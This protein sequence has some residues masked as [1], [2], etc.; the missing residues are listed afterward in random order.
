MAGHSPHAA[1]GVVPL[2]PVVLLCF[3]LFS[4]TAVC[5]RTWEALSQEIF[6]C[7]KNHSAAGSH[8]ITGAC[9]RSHLSVAPLRVAHGLEG[10]VRG[11]VF[12]RADAPDPQPSQV[13][14]CLFAE[15]ALVHGKGFCLLWAS[16]CSW[17][18]SLQG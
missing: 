4:L 5:G 2:P 18:N 8:R 11:L 17:G 9:W 1:F 14:L 6:F 15:V 16:T 12:S 10:S 3:V 13:L 7:N